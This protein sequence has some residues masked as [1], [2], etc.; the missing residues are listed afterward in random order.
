MSGAIISYSGYAGVFR[1]DMEGS[2]AV[3]GGCCRALHD[4]DSV[5]FMCGAYPWLLYAAYLGDSAVALLDQGMTLCT[6]LS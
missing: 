3:L 4:G 6:E 2:G 5:A 1:Y